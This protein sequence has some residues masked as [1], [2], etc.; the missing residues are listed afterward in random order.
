MQLLFLIV[1]IMCTHRRITKFFS[2]L[3]PQSFLCISSIPLQLRYSYAPHP[4]TQYAGKEYASNDMGDGPNKK[5]KQPTAKPPPR[6]RRRTASRRPS[7]PSI[8]QFFTPVTLLTTDGSGPCPPTAPLPAWGA[9]NEALPPIT[10]RDGAHIFSSNTLAIAMSGQDTIAARTALL[11]IPHNQRGDI[12][13]LAEALKPFP[14]A[15]AIKHLSK[16]YCTIPRSGLCTPLVI[17]HLLNGP[18]TG[19]LLHPPSRERFMETLTH[20]AECTTVHRLTEATDAMTRYHGHLTRHPTT[21]TFSRNLDW[22]P[23][24]L[25]LAVLRSASIPA[26][27]WME[28]TSLPTPFAPPWLPLS[29]LHDPRDN[30]P[31]PMTLTITQLLHMADSAIPHVAYA[32]NH[33]F[34]PTTATVHLGRQVRWLLVNM[35]AQI[36]AR[37]GP[38]S[39]DSALPDTDTVT[40]NSLQYTAH[41]MAVYVPTAMHRQLQEACKFSTGSSLEEQVRDFFGSRR[42]ICC[43]HL[44][45]TDTPARIPA[46]GFCSL[47][48]LDYINNSECQNPPLVFPNL[49]R[50]N[51]MVSKILDSPHLSSTHGDPLRR[52]QCSFLAQ[53][54]LQSPR[55]PHLSMVAEWANIL[56]PTS[57][58]LDDDTSL[59]DGW[60]RAIVI[61]TDSSPVKRAEAGSSWTLSDLRCL[62]R[63]RHLAL[64]HSHY[65]PTYPPTHAVENLI[66]G[67]VQVA[68]NYLTTRLQVHHQTICPPELVTL[69]SPP[70]D[71]GR[72]TGPGLQGRSSQHP[73]HA[74]P[75]ELSS[76]EASDDRHSSRVSFLPL[77]PLDGSPPCVTYGPDPRPVTHPALC[78]YHPEKDPGMVNPPKARRYPR[79]AHG[80]PRVVAPD[81]LPAP[82]SDDPFYTLAAQT[83][84]PD[85]ILVGPATAPGS[86][87]GAFAKQDIEVD[88]KL[89]AYV[90]A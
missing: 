86:Y 67:L 3:R 23:A 68:I 84:N 8:K 51:S 90:S 60:I 21:A 30:Y 52:I 57:L 79:L 63:C 50:A 89:G 16:D 55:W 81:P 24:D 29:G 75:S 61:P 53:S 34:L 36:M 82:P 66:D 28:E 38:V 74:A 17:D 11:A 31:S 40:S 44:P 9:Q 62:P 33:H 87:Y 4:S 37:D 64:A 41:G 7:T 71:P 6:T 73:A 70:L 12:E 43:A 77:Q 20:I 32:Q 22:M 76:P 78:P 54:T 13:V 42:S 10:S 48:A 88:T 56:Q 85:L 45:S 5:T 46:T 47:H 26:T 15:V 2:A 58:W 19:S 69:L 1:A 80:S 27:V 49:S 72:V 35:S 65:S 14:L 18:P 59:P 25:L 39:P 83:H